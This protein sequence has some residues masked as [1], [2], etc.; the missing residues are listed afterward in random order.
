MAANGVAVVPDVKL[1]PDTCHNIA[2]KHLK[3]KLLPTKPPVVEPFI[4]IEMFEEPITLSNTEAVVVAD[5]MAPCKST[6]PVFVITLWLLLVT[7]VVTIKSYVAPTTGAGSVYVMPAAV[8]NRKVA[9]LPA[10]V[11][12]VPAALPFTG[13]TWAPA[14]VTVPLKVMAP[15]IVHAPPITAALLLFKPSDSTMGKAFS[16]S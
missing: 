15:F 11:S 10:A 14:N 4:V 1:V 8:S 7:E 3:V 12:V 6:V 2:L 16:R 9:P 5:V 13:L